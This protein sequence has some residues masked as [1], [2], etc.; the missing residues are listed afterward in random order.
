MYLKKVCSFQCAIKPMYNKIKH[1]R[2]INN[3]KHHR[4]NI[5]NER[6]LLSR[7]NFFRFSGNRVIETEISLYI[8]YFGNT[9]SSS[10]REFEYL[11]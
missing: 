1:L 4:L 9:L 6:A 7:E 5:K 8:D 2:T 3:K 11:I 10:K